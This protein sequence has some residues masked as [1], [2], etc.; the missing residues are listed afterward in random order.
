MVPTRLPLRLDVWPFLIIY[1]VLAYLGYHQDEDTLYVKLTTIGT[2]FMHCLLYIFGHWSQRFRSVVQYSPIRG[3][4]ENNLE[5]A[6]H[7]YIKESK[8]GKNT[9]HAIVDFCVADY[10]GESVYFFHFEQRKFFYNPESKQF[11][12]MKPRFKGSTVRQ[13]FSESQSHQLS[14]RS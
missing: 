14:Q 12:R 13:L 3:P 4:V 5:K 11:E 6:S 10:E 2:L 8:P 7:L 1:A 9:T